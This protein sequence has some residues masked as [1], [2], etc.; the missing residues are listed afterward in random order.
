MPFFKT[1]K[2]AQF[3]RR[4]FLAG[5]IMALGACSALP[6]AERTD[7]R[8]PY[9]GSNR[10]AFAFNMNLDSAAIEPM[11]ARYRQ[12]VPDRGKQALENHLDWA[13]LPATA[14]NS[15]LQGRFENAG[16]SILHFAINGLTF[17]LAE[18][19]EDPKEVKA[20]DFGQTLAAYGAPQGNY[21]MVPFLG[22]NTTRSLAGS[23]VDS[24]TNPMGFVKAGSAIKTV[25]AL[26]PPTRAVVFRASQ[27]EAINDVKYNALDPYARTRALYYQ[28]RAGRLNARTGQPTENKATDS[29][30]ESFLEDP[31]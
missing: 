20:Q 12:S 6:E 14:F 15:T 1:S 16:L 18:L 27:F 2:T 23:V 5:V 8:D 7:N 26:Q 25:R 19:T 9:E 21:L 31:K 28:A 24:V 17:G 29:L 13:R 22:S 30:F 3:L 11:A 4:Y 10:R